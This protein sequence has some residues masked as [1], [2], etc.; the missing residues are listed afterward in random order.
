MI[1]LVVGLAIG[2]MVASCASTRIKQ[3]SGE[4]FLKEA[5]RTDQMNSFLYTS[6]I[7]SSPQ[8]AYLE[9]GYPAFIGR[10]M[11]ATVYWVA[12]S[13]L[14][15]N[16]VSQIKSG[17]PPWTNWMQRVS[18]PKGNLVLPAVHVP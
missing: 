14:P 7:G 4:E 9:S 6:Y 3:L 16:I 5:Q 15:S 10:G 11:R 18:Q 2:L 12:V 13:D 17:I 8:R 1:V